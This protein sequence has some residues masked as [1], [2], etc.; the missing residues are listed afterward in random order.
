MDAPNGSYSIINKEN[1]KALS[2]VVTL[3]V[4][5]KTNRNFGKSRMKNNTNLK[6][7]NDKLRN[8]ERFRR[9]R[10]TKSCFLFITNRTILKELAVLS[11]Q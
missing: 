11:T 8:S 2:T 1:L 5:S 6:F 10:D 4:V 7:L 9:S 3:N